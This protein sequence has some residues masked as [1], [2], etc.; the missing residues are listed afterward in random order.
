M[1]NVELLHKELL[2]DSRE[3]SSLEESMLIKV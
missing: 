2:P 3:D 1:Q